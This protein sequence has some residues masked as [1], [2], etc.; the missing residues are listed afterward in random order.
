M[1]EWNGEGVDVVVH[2][3]SYLVDVIFFEWFRYLE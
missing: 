2:D 1:D 3:C